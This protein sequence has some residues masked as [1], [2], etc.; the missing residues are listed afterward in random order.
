MY[1]ITD[2]HDIAKLTYITIAS[3]SHILG[4]GSSDNETGVYLLVALVVG[5][6]VGARVV[7]VSPH[8]MH[9][10]QQ[11]PGLVNLHSPGLHSII[12]HS[13]GTISTDL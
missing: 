8:G 2:I 3:V 1:I 10:G 9:L 11:W 4:T 12:A 6:V 7:G 5:Y 13:I